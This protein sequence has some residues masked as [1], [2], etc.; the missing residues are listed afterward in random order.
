MLNPVIAEPRHATSPVARMKFVGTFSIVS[1]D[2]GSAF[3]SGI[4]VVTV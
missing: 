1:N 2:M 3:K 4:V